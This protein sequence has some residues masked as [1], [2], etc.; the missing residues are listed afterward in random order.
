M[1]PFT[2]VAALCDLYSACKYL[3][4][5]HVNSHVLNDESRIGKLCIMQVTDTSIN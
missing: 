5:W 1:T 2:Y 4:F 3:V